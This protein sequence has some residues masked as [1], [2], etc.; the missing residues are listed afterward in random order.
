MKVCLDCGATFADE[1]IKKWK[2]VHGEWRSGCP[3]CYGAFSEAEQCTSC[4]EHYPEGTLF[5]GICSGC[6]GSTIN[7]DTALQF[8]LDTE[9]YFDLFMF[10][11]WLDTPL[12]TKAGE[13]KIGQKMHD[14]LICQY[15]RERAEANIGEHAFL[16]A[17]KEFILDY[18]GDCGKET[19]AKWL[20][21]M[22]DA[23]K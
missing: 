21:R 20:R 14:Y 8:M 12:P 18:D 6:L 10:E 3:C 11:I 13:P 5:D 22:R 2:E 23:K 1:N 7:Y 16:D 4:G 15:N 17:I 9:D 19:Y